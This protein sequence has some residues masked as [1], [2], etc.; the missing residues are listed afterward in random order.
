MSNAE[1]VVDPSGNL[2]AGVEIKIPFLLTETDRSA[3]VFLLS[4]FPWALDFRLETPDGVIID[5]AKAAALP[6]VDKVMSNRID[7]YRMSL[8]VPIGFGVREGLW[9]AVL[10]IRKDRYTKFLGSLDQTGL[11]AAVHGVPYILNVHAFSSL[12]MKAW[13][14]QQSYQPGAQ[15][16]LRASLTESG[17]PVEKRAYVQADVQKPDGSSTTLSLAEVEPGV[18]EST[19]TAVQ[20]GIYPARFRAKGTTLRGYPFTREQLRTAAVWRG[21]D[22]PP[23]SGTT[24]PPAGVDWCRLIACLLH[25]KGILTLLERNGIDAEGL[26]RCWKEQCQDRMPSPEIRRI[27]SSPELLRELL[28]HVERGS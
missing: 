10:G 23:P 2:P 13:V 9:H 15:L 5:E 20:A 19:L 26:A 7:K 22:A 18:F 27:L 28:R 17:L 12:R 14:T 24:Q 16:V 25:D 3:T 21:G 1:V 4:P 8:P 6:G 11:G